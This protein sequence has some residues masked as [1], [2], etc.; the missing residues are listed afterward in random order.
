MRLDRWITNPL[1]LICLIFGTQWLIWYLLMPTVPVTVTSAPRYPGGPAYVRFVVFLLTF[2]GSIQLGRLLAQRYV[3][4]TSEAPGADPA[5]LPAARVRLLMRVAK[6]AAL[7]TL[8]AELFYVREVILDPT[9]ILRGAEAGDFASAG[10][11]VQQ[12]VIPGLTSLVNLFFAATAIFG[13]LA[14]HPATPRGTRR[15]AIRW[16]VGIGAVALVHSLVLSARMMFLWY[17]MTLAGAFLLLQG[18]RKHLRVRWL[19]AALALGT[20]VTWGGATLR[21]GGRYAFGTGS[22]LLD[23]DTQA[24]VRAMLVEGYFAGDFNNALNL[25]HCEPALSLVAFTMFRYVGPAVT[26]RPE[27]NWSCPINASAGGTVNVLAI[28]WTE[29]GWL[30]LIVALATGVWVGVTYTVATRRIDRLT[31]GSLFY[32]VTFPGLVSLTRMHFFLNTYFA[33][34]VLLFTL[35]AVAQSWISRG[36]AWSTASASTA[37]S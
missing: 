4:A 17:G 14:A 28:W 19:V 23:A 37:A 8:A 5:P 10:S 34:P 1:R 16:L 26:L 18:P 25:L 6:F 7:L 2:L 32:L 15:S 9:L 11:M 24:Y 12:G 31:T 20:L 33:V 30:G 13:A 22:G 36:A 21:D 27:G 29:Y 3:S 35:L